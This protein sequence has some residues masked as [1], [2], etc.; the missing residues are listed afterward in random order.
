MLRQDVLALQQSTCDLEGGTESQGLGG[1]TISTI[2]QVH[3]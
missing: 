1:P 2:R 3:K